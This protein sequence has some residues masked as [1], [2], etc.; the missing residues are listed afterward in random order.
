MHISLNDFTFVCSSSFAITTFIPFNKGIK[1][2]K[3]NISN[4]IVVIEA[5]VSLSVNLNFFIIP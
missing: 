1:L 3:T 2:S 4:D 5:I